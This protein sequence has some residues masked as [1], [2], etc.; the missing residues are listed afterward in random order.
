MPPP[1]VGDV[2]TDH[3]RL[4]FEKPVRT[5]KRTWEGRILKIDRFGNIVTNLHRRDFADLERRQCA[6]ALGPHRVTVLA[7]NYAQTGPGELFLLFGSGGYLEVSV[8]QASAARAIGCEV[9]APVELTV[10]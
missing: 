3:L 7:T 1:T 6:L 2:V 8:G 9:G 5:G 4:N 10:W